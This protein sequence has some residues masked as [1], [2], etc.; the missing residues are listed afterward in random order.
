MAAILKTE[1][2]T[3]VYRDGTRAL[4]GVDLQVPEGSIFGLLG[5]NGAGKTTLISIVTTLRGKT[6]GK[7]YLDGLDLDEDQNAIRER[8]GV[9]FQERVRESNLT[10]REVLEY[11]GVLYGMNRACLEEKISELL[12]I[13]DL[14]DVADKDVKT[15]SGGM[16]RRLELIKGMMT[17][18]RIL[19]LDE[20]TVG[21]DPQSRKQMWAL[22]QRMRDRGTTIF[23][24]SHYIEEIERNADWVAIIDK[25]SCVDQG[26]P[27]TLL[28]KYKNAS[29]LSPSS[30]EDIYLYLSGG[31]VKEAVR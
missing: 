7:V 22:I 1:G 17:E 8:I 31:A 4:K 2:L 11:H 29:A 23:V 20:P 6:D 21:L 19:F 30:L 12:M 14:D 16:L 18:P 13:A 5:A 28:E 15:Y 24:T 9:T 27:A 26:R 3:K 25:G 10:G